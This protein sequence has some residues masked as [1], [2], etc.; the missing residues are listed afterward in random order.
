M[1]DPQLCHI[2]EG[3]YRMKAY[4]N[5]WVLSVDG[6][7]TNTELLLVDVGKRQ[8]LSTTGKG[9]NPNVYGEDG[10]ETVDH[11]ISSLLTKAGCPRQNLS[12]CIVG[13]AGISNL[14][15]RRKIEQKM[16]RTL[17]NAV[18]RLTSDAELAHRCIWGFDPGM[19]L[20]VGTG[21]IAVGVNSEG[22][23]QRSGGFGYQLG[24]QGGAYWLGKTILRELITAERSTSDDV[25]ELRDGVLDSLGQSQFED[26][27][28][29]LSKG[30]ESVTRVAGLAP[31]VL[32][33]AEQGNLLASQVVGWG[34]DALAEMMEELDQSMQFG[35]DDARIGMGGSLIIKSDFYRGLI[36]DNLLYRFKTVEW[37]R[38]DVPPVFGGLVLSDANILPKDFRD[39]TIDHV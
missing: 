36:T 35:E 38:P 9:S 16:S 24:D 7:A 4:P 28:T 5:P 8:G 2:H 34:V 25:L 10:L 13:M 23:F 20:V 12:E 30:D 6:G 15:H 32:S 1:V 33:F 18:L 26:A 11:L 37:V 39:L 3:Q 19:T 21:A 22:R 27:L 14:K 29:L 17:P 31:V